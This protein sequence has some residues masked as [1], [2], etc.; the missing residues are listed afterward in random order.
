MLKLLFTKL[1]RGLAVLSLVVGTWLSASAE[2]V[3]IDGLYYELNTIYNTAFVTYQSTTNSNYAALPPNVT[4]PSEITYNN[5]TFKVTAIQDHAFANCTALESISIPGTVTRIGDTNYNSSSTATYLPFYN[6]TSLKTVRFEDGTDPVSLGVSYYSSNSSYPKGLFYYCPLEEVYIGRNITYKDYGSGSSSFGS[7]P[8]YYGYSAFYQQQNLTKVTFG[9]TV[10]D[11]PAYLFYNCT[12]LSDVDFGQSLTRISA[13]AFRNCA[14]TSVNLPNTVTAIGANAF[15]FNKSLT[16]VDLGGSVETIADNAFNS[17]TALSDIRLGDKLTSIG[18][19]AFGAAGKNASELTLSLPETLTAIGESAF[20]GSGI[21]TV[22]IP[23]S[24]NSIGAS[25]FASCANLTSITVGSGCK[26]IPTSFLSDCTVLSEIILSEGVTEISDK[27]FS[28]CTALESISI[29]C[30]VTIIGSTKYNSSSTATYLPFYNCSSLKTVR[31]ED[32]AEPV[33]LGVSYYSSNSSYP[34]GLFYYCPLEEVYIGRNITYKDYGS[35]SS[36][37]ESSPEYYGY[38]AFYNQEKLTKV[39]VGEMVAD[40]PAYLFYKNA[41]ITLMRLPSVKNI[42]KAAFRECTKLTTL[43]LG[44]SLE[45]VGDEAFYGCT[46]ITKLTFP[47]ATQSIGAGAF[48]GC[49]SVAE[50]TVGKGLRSIGDGGFYGCKSFTAL[51]LPDEFTTMGESAF[52][53][54]A[55]LTVAKIGNSLTAMPAKAFKNC[56]SLSEMVIPAT[57]TS[58]GDEAFYNDSGLAT[59]TMNEGLQTIGSRVFWNNSG[60]MRF[61]IPGTVTSIGQNSFYGCTRVAYLIFSDGEQ[62]LTID[63]ASCRS[64][65]IDALTSNS[66]YRN[67]RYDYFYDCP[68][69]FLTLGRNLTYAYYADVDM[70]DHDGSSFKSVSRASAPFVNNTELRSVR[71]GPKVTFLWHHLLNGCSNVKTLTMSDGMQ[72]VYSYAMAN[73]TGLSEL[74]FPA[75]LVL[76]SDYACF[77]DTTLTSVTFNEAPGNNLSMTI[78]KSTFRN[79]TRLTELTLPSKTTSVG[80]FCFGNAS[81]LISLTITDSKNALWFGSGALSSTGSQISSRPLFG[82]SNLQSLYIGRDLTYNASSSYGFSPF[83]AQSYLT[84]VR[85]SQAGTVTVCNDYLLYKVNNCRSLTLPESLAKIG[86]YT[87]AA[88]TSLGGITIPDKV[89]EIGTYAFSD[90]DALKYARLS[91]SCEWLKEGLFNSCDSLEAIVIPPVVTKMDTKMFANC[92]SLSEVTFE[93]GSN[94]VEVGYGA[95]QPGYG[96]FRDCPV[97]TLNLDRWMSYNTDVASRSPFYSVATLKTINFGENVGVIDKY[98]FSYCSGIEDLYL[99]DNIESVGLWGFRGCSSLKSVRLS[100]RLSQISDYGF[101][102]CTA[103]DNVAFPASM[104]SIA[105]NSFSNCTSLRKLDLGESLLVI[106][107]AAF[108]NDAALEGIEI[109]E[110]LYGLGVEAFA[111]CTA[112]PNVTVRGVSSVGKQA[113]SGCTGLEWVELSDKTTSLGEDSFAGCSGVKYVKS[114]AEFPPEGLVNFPEDVVAAGTLYVPDGSEDYYRASPTWENWYEIKPISELSGIDE[115]TGDSVDYDIEITG[116]TVALTNVPEGTL[117]RLFSVE[118]RLL[119][120]ILA[121]GDEVRFDTV[122]GGIYIVSVGH[123]AMKIMIP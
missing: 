117:C 33:S 52:E 50:V 105:D 82:N 92:R 40:I 95:S 48:Y 1:G 29:P 62:T 17:C 110:T 97:V 70:Y 26:V 102:E 56:V 64:S 53:G 85:F 71:I 89:T 75:P 76:L 93:G 107:P 119:S 19:S 8:E 83:Y 39:T 7:S 36:S 10:T 27:A 106:G 96:L 45:T 109:P 60:V 14:L 16:S 9:P 122:H 57:A 67:R 46:N 32:G 111:G 80:D 123:R 121:S 101:S 5:L 12:N 84:D 22:V 94:I 114:L 4:I 63:N 72:Q 112:L 87:F 79:C 18:Q 103:L 115:V 116:N 61:T 59:I 28:G 21:K 2:S 86:N 34:K 15:Q 55:K 38:S 104:T 120:S 77:N 3:E 68:V 43:T 24:V 44:Q 58:I 113:F 91:A 51:I 31:F 30:T 25:A 11:M 90:D 66:T 118:G 108:K 98:M 54:C 42:G 6:C 78:G 41:S 47:D 65:K 23:N 81:G 20:Y 49:S 73:C 100:E 88:M 69:R 37:F 99:P 35:G 13:Y 74:V